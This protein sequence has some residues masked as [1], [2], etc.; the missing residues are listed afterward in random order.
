[1]RLLDLKELFSSRLLLAGLIF[2]SLNATFSYTFYHVN[3]HKIF[4]MLAGVT[5][6]FIQFEILFFK[7]PVQKD[8]LKT[9]AIVSAPLIAT[10]PGYLIHRGGFNY[11]FE[12]ELAANLILILWVMYIYKGAD[13]KSDLSTLL[14]FMGL[15]VI[16]VG[17]W[18]V[19]EQ[20][21]YNPFSLEAGFRG[22]KAV[23]TFGNSNYFAGFLNILLPVYFV[24]S[25]PEIAPSNSASTSFFHRLKRI[26]FQKKRFF[27]LTVFVFGITGLLLTESR[28]AIP[29]SLAGIASAVFV[30]ILLRKRA[31]KIFFLVLL[32]LL[33]VSVLVAGWLLIFE[34]DLIMETRFGKLFGISG[35]Y[36]RFFPWKA[37]WDSIKASPVTGYGLGS[38]YNLFFEFLD[39]FAR[40]YSFERSYNHAHSE[41]LEYLQE[42]GIIGLLTNACFWGYIIFQLTKI[43]RNPLTDW[44]KRL[45]TGIAGGLLAYMIQSFFSVAPRMMVVRVPLYTLFGLTLAMTLFCGAEKS[46]KPSPGTKPRLFFINLSIFAL[47][48]S[49]SFYLPWV[50]RQNLHVNTTWNNLSSKKMEKLERETEKNHKN[51]IYMLNSLML[52]QLKAGRFSRM[53]ETCK[54]IDMMIPHYR[55][56]DS[57]KAVASVSSGYFDKALKFAMTKQRR[58]KYHMD[59][60]KLLF[61]LSAKSGDKEAFFQP[62]SD[63]VVMSLFM[64]ELI[65]FKELNH[66]KTESGDIYEPINFTKNDVGPHI[67]ISE[68]AV[69]L[70][71]KATLK[72]SFSPLSAYE[73]E[74]FT[75]FVMEDFLSSSFLRID[76][77]PEYIPEAESL[78]KSAARYNRLYMENA[79][80][81]RLL[82]PGTLAY[83]K[84]YIE[85]DPAQKRDMPPQ[86]EMERLS[87]ALEQ[88]TDWNQHV[89][90]L[91]FISLFIRAFNSA[92]LW[93]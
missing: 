40:L 14:F 58:D 76:I 31:R 78:K 28:A 34:Y 11:N 69:D 32:I 85:S 46:E 29:A 86:D 81:K 35:W 51:D 19:A 73:K 33:A 2:F 52:A 24:F 67:K 82:W 4:V 22:F 66:I 75:N 88:K 7:R 93:S 20:T 62:L 6:L 13:K 42:A 83:Y 84:K 10:F 79:M 21:G 1:M 48:V 59:T 47:L 77:L 37:A 92:A 65:E 15:T 36:H 70:F 53:K 3:S 68:A 23:A 44:Q 39:P 71:M 91:E 90:K 17:G 89:K 45:A 87:Y 38:S 64:S 27:Y 25:L 74:K 50:A 8:I 60:M 5:L 55:D 80:T 30:L 72:N 43:L 9:L 63:L 26:Q 54:K 41:I 56:N 18:A 49:W 12:Y 57:Y 16:Y 61:N